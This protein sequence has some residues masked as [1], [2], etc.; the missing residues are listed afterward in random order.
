MRIRP[1]RLPY[2]V[3]IG[4]FVALATWT[5]L[6]T[7]TSVFDD[8]E[9]AA[10]QDGDGDTPDGGEEE[11]LPTPTP[12]P[13][14]RPS[15]RLQG[16]STFAPGG[17]LNENDRYNPGERVLYLVRL[18]NAGPT[19][20]GPVQVVVTLDEEFIG[21]IEEVS[22]GG[23]IDGARVIWSFDQIEAGSEL[24]LQFVAT[25]RQIFPPGVSRVTG[26]V[27][28]QSGQTPIAEA[29]VASIE[30]S[31]PNL[32]LVDDQIELVTDLNENGNPDPGD[33]LRFTIAYQNTGG[34]PS[35]EA[36]IVADYPDDLIAEI[37]SNPGD[38]QDTGDTLSWLI[39]SI[40]IEAE[41]RR[42]QFSVRLEER[43]PA[44]TTAFELPVEIRGTSAVLDMTTISV[45]LAGPSVMVT[46]SFELAVDSNSNGL[47]DSGDT[48]QVTV[49]Y[50]N[51][52]TDAAQNV[53]I[54]STFPQEQVEVSGVSNDGGTTLGDT[55]GTVTWP[56]VPLLSPGESA[57]FT[58]QARIR[59]LDATVSNISFGFAVDSDQTLAGTQ[60][61]NVQVV[62]GQ[63]VGVGDLGEGSTVTQEKP[64]QGSGRLTGP[65]IA[66]LVG[67]FL[68]F[69][70]LSITYVA[71]RVLPS[72]P[73]ERDNDT[74]AARAAN[75]R[76]V[77][78]LI[79][80]VIITA[81]LFSVM[82]LGLQNALDRESI[83]SIIAGIVGY[84]AGRVAGQQ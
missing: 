78:E 51:V 84:V 57:Q 24:G 63:G 5:L 9:P 25:L 37:T 46:P 2:G 43:L 75:R 34:G 66:S 7:V 74:E 35:Q 30:V 55:Q 12:Q 67:G 41:P 6:N 8:V 22:G 16:I 72:T 38:A 76:M 13:T 42:V 69:S 61:L 27:V 70:L 45:P 44:G 28:V 48:V 49:R 20:T 62:P 59:S 68:I 29:N 18:A 53:V 17:D 47:A 15:L 64:T 54:R 58:Y 81:I 56:P 40:P 32:R 11:E 10:A 19:N 65:V 21:N 4:L 83:N 33:T 73:E 71:S 36:A 50:E 77:R 23:V 26:N 3:L 52:G 60:Q 1:K 82:V 14:P 31:G 80:G 39:G 79:E